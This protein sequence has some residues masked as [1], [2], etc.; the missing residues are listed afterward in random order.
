MKSNSGSILGFIIIAVIFSTV[1][2]TELGWMKTISQPILVT[3][4][5]DNSI[6]LKQ[7]KFRNGGG[8]IHTALLSPANKTYWYVPWE[9]GDEIFVVKVPGMVHDMPTPT[10]IAINYRSQRPEIPYPR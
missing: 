3:T 4:T 5:N 6:G 1:V 7:V 10:Y 9:I 8:P 2:A